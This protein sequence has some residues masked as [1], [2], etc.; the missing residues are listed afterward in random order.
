MNEN[1]AKGKYREFYE[2]QLAFIA[3]KDVEGLIHT[4][5]TEDAELLNFDGHAL[6]SKTTDVSNCDAG[7]PGNCAGQL[8]NDNYDKDL[9]SG[10]GTT[11]DNRDGNWG[12][13]FFFKLIKKLP[14]AS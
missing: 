13:D 5:Y 1:L 12:G 6:V 10:N 4:N 3:A 2:R 9:H 11:R 8:G 7:S 14:G